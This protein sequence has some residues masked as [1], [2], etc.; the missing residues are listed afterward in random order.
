MGRDKAPVLHK[1]G[2]GI[3]VSV[4]DVFSYHTHMHSYYEMTLYEPFGGRITV[5]DKAFT[6]DRPTVVLVIPSDVH[7]IEVPEN[8]KAGFIKI[9]F[10]P[11]PALVGEGIGASVILQGLGEGDLL[12][13]LF[14]EIAAAAEGSAYK[15]LLVHTA[16]LALAEKGV[17][18]MPAESSGGSELSKRA[19][20]IINRR[21]GESISLPSVAEELFVSPQY[22]SAVFKRNIGIT[23]IAHLKSVRLRRAAVLLLE[24]KDSVTEIAARC[25]YGNLSHFLRSFKRFFGVSPLAYRK[26]GS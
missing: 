4:A 25:G 2:K 12:Y 3:A 9:A 5:N 23:F 8:A 20:Q 22:L 18:V 1:S 10:D 21:F 13:R 19:L 7:R 6:I 26:R 14:P 17:R 15:T 11:D 24:T 16:L